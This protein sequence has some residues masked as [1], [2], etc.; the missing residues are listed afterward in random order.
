[1][2][3]VGKWRV[4]NIHKITPFELLKRIIDIVRCDFIGS[5]EE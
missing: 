1:V 2:G 3:G 4:N 5:D